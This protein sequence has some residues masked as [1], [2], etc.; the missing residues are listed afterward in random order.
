MPEPHIRRIVTGHDAIGNAVVIAN[1]E[2]PL[3]HTDSRRPGYRTTD[4]WR[5]NTTP[6]PIVLRAGDRTRAPRYSGDK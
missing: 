2:P 4:P 3:V 5:T 6:I 1:G